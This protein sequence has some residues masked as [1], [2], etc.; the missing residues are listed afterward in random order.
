V[1]LRDARKLGLYPSVTNVLSVVSAPQL[2][3]WKQNNLLNAAMSMP[4]ATAAEIVE[5]AQRISKEAMRMGT[6]VHSAIEELIKIDATGGVPNIHE[7]VPVSTLNAFAKVYQVEKITNPR[8]ELSFASRSGYAGQ[9]DLVCNWRDGRKAIIDWK[10]QRTK[11]GR[12]SKKY[13]KWAAQLA[14]YAYG[15]CEDGLFDINDYDLVNVII[16]T[17]EPERE[18]EVHVWDNNQRWLDAWWSAFALWRSPLYKG[19][20]PLAHAE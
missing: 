12:A 8:P 6:L 16:S 4:G 18:V 2:E 17:T 19:Y 15:H 13:P 14:A 9:I 7:D 20:E 11:E 1:N 10:T 3:A 5:E